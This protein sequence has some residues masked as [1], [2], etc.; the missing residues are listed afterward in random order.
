MRKVIAAEHLSLDGVMEGTEWKVPYLTDEGMAI[1][2]TLLFESGALLMGRVTYQW[3]SRAWSKSKDETGFADRMNSLPK[4]VASSTLHDLEWNATR[5]DGD[6][7]EEV[8]KLK[9]P[10]GGHLLIYGSAALVQYLMQHNLID[11]YRLMIYPVVLGRGKRL[12]AEGIATT[13][14]LV[15]SQAL[16][17]GVVVQTYKPASQ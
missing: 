5:I 8:S 2:R 7:A 9:N 14:Q 1:A 10:S 16:A 13:L 6:V 12:F 15:E 4:H 11:E 17:S 3:L